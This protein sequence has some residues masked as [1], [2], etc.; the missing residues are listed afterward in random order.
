[1]VAADRGT[2][3]SIDNSWQSWNGVLGG[4]A[5][6]I[7]IEHATRSAP[8]TPVVAAHVN[9]LLPI[10]AGEL[11]ACSEFLRAGG[12][13]VIRSVLVQSGRTAVTATTLFGAARSEHS[14]AGVAMPEVP[15][16]DDCPAVPFPMPFG[17]HFEYRAASPALPFSGA[18][19]AGFSAWMKPLVGSPTPYS[20][21]A[22]LLD[23]MPPALYAIVPDPFPIPSAE[24][25]VNFVAPERVEA[26]H[27]YL[28]TIETEY[29]SD[30]WC[31]DVS[32]VWSPSGHLLASARQTRVL[33]GR[34][35]PIP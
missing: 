33:L 7:A 30:G 29:A 8:G 24:M 18:D 21:A 6:G 31:S 25:S 34:L 15:A 4:Y 11:L 3:I 17:Q 26:H 19:R 27:W 14:Y 35:P 20:A 1:M 5:A 10:K 16:P 23:A 28:V 13:S 22:A 32:R 9:F 12:R 2:P